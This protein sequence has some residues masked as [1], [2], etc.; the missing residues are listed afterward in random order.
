MREVDRNNFPVNVREP[1]SSSIL[2]L[3]QRPH[4]CKNHLGSDGACV[5]AQQLVLPLTKTEVVTATGGKL[6]AQGPFHPEG[7]IPHSDL[8]S[9]HVLDMILHFLPSG[10]YL[11]WLSEDLQL[12]LTKRSLLQSYRGVVSFR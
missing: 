5:R 2:G 8:D 7:T 9:T 10:P 11:I 1:L 12:P 3:S 4:G 6:I